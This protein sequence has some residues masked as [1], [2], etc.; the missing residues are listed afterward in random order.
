MNANNLLIS[1]LVAFPLAASTA[2]AQDKKGALK[3]KEEIVIHEVCD[4][5]WPHMK[6]FS[7]PH[8]WHPGFAST[9]AKG[10]NEAGATRTIML[11]GGGKVHEK[12][13][14]YSSKAQSMSYVITEVDPKVL[15]V[16]NYKSRLRTEK[17]GSR[18]EV[19]WQ[20]IF[21]N[22]N[23]GMSDDELKK[24]VSGIYRAGLESIKKM[25]TQ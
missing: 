24:M 23:T 21:D 13:V 11:E 16:M 9:E 22:A 14:K 25:S 20:G 4:K 17:E 18:C 8:K 19:D 1:L 10:G 3:V 7:E 12:L 2:W 5:V 6:N 15:P